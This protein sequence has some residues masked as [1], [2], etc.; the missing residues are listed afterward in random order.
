MPII[1]AR[2]YICLDNAFTRGDVIE[3]ELSKEI[4]NSR[5]FRLIS[6]LNIVLDR[7]E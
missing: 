2:F 6:K 3:N 5:L 4:E 7:Q 1:G